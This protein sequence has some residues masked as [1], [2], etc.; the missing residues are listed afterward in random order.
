MRSKPPSCLGCPC[1]S[2]GTDFSAVTGTGSLGVMVVAE[3][4]GEYEA[5]EGRPLVEWAPAGGVFERS[6]NRLGLS[7]E[8]F[9]LTNTLRCRPKKDWLVKS[10]WEFEALNHCRPNLTAAV[11]SHPP[12]AILAL[13]N[14]ALRETTGLAGLT[15][16]VTHLSGYV[17]PGLNDI[18]TTCT[19]HPAFIRRGK[20]AY[21]G[22]RYK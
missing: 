20:A 3:A 16:S 15:R 11:A 17:V 4:S 6:L 21:L 12:R 8:Q 7:R 18:P 13:G 9:F 1:Y 10:P 5:L 2:H 19:V 14:V 22:G